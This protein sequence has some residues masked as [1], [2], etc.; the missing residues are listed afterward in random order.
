M[1]I[2]HRNFMGAAAGALVALTLAG[3]AWAE[4]MTLTHPQGQ[5]VLAAKPETVFVTDWAAFDNL[6][7][8][9]VPVAGV[10]GVR[11]PG[12]LADQAPADAV[13]I[14]SLQEPDFEAIAAAKPDLVI[15]AAR[16]R[17]AYPTMS[18]IAPAFDASIDDSALIP[19]VRSQL[20]TYGEVFGVQ[21]RAA[22]L[23]ANLDAKLA[24]ARDLAKGKGT[25]LVIV[26]N[27]G[28]I[29][30]YGPSS[31]IAWVY[32]ELAV[33]S[34]FDN[35][36]DGDHGGDAI[37]FEYLAEHNPDWLFIVDRDAGV[38]TSGEGGAA[39][40]LLDNEIIHGTNFWSKDQM[41]FLDPAAAYTTMHGYQGLML[42]LDQVI[43]G[44]QKAG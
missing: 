24:E 39:R 13:E 23:I 9:G 29:G 35:V 21:D 17:T 43:A 2:F 30:I 27:A 1:T 3:G 41:I 31:R 22:E 4:E 14:G 7:A 44:Y 40:A 33:P 37:S 20:K 5:T 8:L 38:G 25:G 15:V 32:D 10:P 42:M 16:S 36:E 18:A 19:G 34:V 28:K 6:S 12:Y 26:T 11:M